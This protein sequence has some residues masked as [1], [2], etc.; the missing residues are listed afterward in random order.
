MVYGVGAVEGYILESASIYIMQ[1]MK[2]FM[3]HHIYFKA[4]DSPV[5]ISPLAATTA[6]G[7][8]KLRVPSA[9][10]LPSLLK[11]PQDEPAGAPNSIGNLSY[12]GTV[13][14]TM[15]PGFDVHMIEFLEVASS[16]KCQ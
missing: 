13:I 12:V 5:W 4:T 16:T 3:K 15:A 2:D 1:A 10:R 7:V 6:P 9:S 8:M 11:T 14:D